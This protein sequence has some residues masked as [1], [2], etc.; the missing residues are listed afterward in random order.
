MTRYS[1]PFEKK[2]ALCTYW[3]DKSSDLHA[4]AAAL[5][6]SRNESL[7]Q[8]VVEECRL[9]DSFD[10]EAAVTPVYYM[11]CGLSLELIYKAIMVAKGQEFKPNHKLVRLAEGAG[12]IL[13]KELSGLLELLTESIEWDGKYPVPTEKNRQNMEKMHDLIHAYLYDRE[14]W[15]LKPNNALS[16]TAFDSLWQE[17]SRTYW[18]FHRPNISKSE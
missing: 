11:L 13:N 2:Q 7:S 12:I 9:G 8:T 16:W 1:D 4:A 18:K 6:C 3:F 14:Q 17:G 5:W 10:M 15:W